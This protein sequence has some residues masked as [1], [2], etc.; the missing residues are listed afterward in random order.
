MNGTAQLTCGGR[1]LQ[2]RAEVRSRLAKREARSRRP[3]ALELLRRAVWLL[4]RLWM[5]ATER[6][7]WQRSRATP[8]HVVGAVRAQRSDE[9]WLRQKMIFV[10]A[11]LDAHRTF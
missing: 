5:V 3:A 10:E 1:E 8:E 7:R 2:L 9:Q 4:E 11:K 6:L